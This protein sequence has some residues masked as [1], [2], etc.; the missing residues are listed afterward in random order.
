MKLPI[1]AAAVALILVG[2]GASDPPHAELL[3]SEWGAEE[4][5]V[6]EVDLG[7]DMSQFND[8]PQAVETFLGATN[9]ELDDVDIFGARFTNCDFGMDDVQFGVRAYESVEAAREQAPASLSAQSQGYM[10][11]IDNYTLWSENKAYLDD[12]VAKLPKTSG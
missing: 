10:Y 4:I 9:C 12:Q 3:S 1:P 6:E 7:V 8:S 2:C 11:R 5:T